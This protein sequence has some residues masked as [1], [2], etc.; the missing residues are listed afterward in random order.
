MIGYDLLMLLEFTYNNTMHFST[1]QFSF[2][3]NYCHRPQADPFQVKDVGSL[4]V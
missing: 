3:S 1:K 4:T 2:F